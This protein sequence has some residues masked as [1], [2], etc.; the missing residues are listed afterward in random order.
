[1]SMPEP[2]YSVFQV[3][4]PGGAFL[5]FAAA[6]LA[7]LAIKGGRWHILAGRVFTIGMVVGAGAGVLLSL[8]REEPAITLLLLGLLALFFTGSGYLAPRIG[9]GSRASYRWDR[10]L[11]VVGV[12]ASVLLIGRDL[13]R[14]TLQAPVQE[15][16]VFGAFGLWVALSH[17]RW[18]GPADPSRWRLEHLTT[19]LAAYTVVW[20]FIFGLYIRTLP[21][22]AQLLIPTGFGL[23]AILWSRRRFGAPPATQ[24]P[25]GVLPRTA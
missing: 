13:P 17:S 16:V 23:A 10:A 25:A 5:A 2:M 3:L 11:T 24:A 9:R 21:Q 22:A 14:T 19:L 7:L 18:R 6:P 8:F 4:H 20:L 15:G 1:M 12:I